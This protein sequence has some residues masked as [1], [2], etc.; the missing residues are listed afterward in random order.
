MVSIMILGWTE[1]TRALVPLAGKAWRQGLTPSSSSGP[2][3][4][5]AALG[6]NPRLGVFQD[7]GDPLTSTVSVLFTGEEKPGEPKNDT[8]Q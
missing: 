3:T 7:L 5:S 8:V 1:R 4:V 6:S 2:W